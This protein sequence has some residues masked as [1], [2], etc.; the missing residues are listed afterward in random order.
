MERNLVDGRHR[1]ETQPESGLVSAILHAATG[2]GEVGRIVDADAKGR[3][4]LQAA[5]KQAAA[6]VGNG[7]QDRRDEVI[8]YARREP[9]AALTAAA[10]FGVLVGLALAIRSRA[11]TGGGR[12]W[13]PQLNSR[14]SFLGRRTGSGWRGFLRLQ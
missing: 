2:S 5:L 14:R 8:A 13:L 6:A 7:I 11:G 12:A 1:V 4:A 3:A 10:G 9:V